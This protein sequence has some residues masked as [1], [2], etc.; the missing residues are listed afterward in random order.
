MKDWRKYPRDGASR[1]ENTLSQPLKEHRVF[2]N[3]KVLSEGWYPITLSKGLKKGEAASFKLLDQRL[4][5][6]RGMD[7]QVR[8]MDSF[9]PHMGADLGNGEVLGNK[10]RCYFHQWEFNGDG[11]VAKVPALET[12]PCLVKQGTYP[13]QEKYGQVWVFAGL[14]ADHE[15]PVAPG[16]E[17]FDA[18][19]IFIK[20]IKLFAHHHVLMAGGID[21]N[22]FATVHNLDMEFDF[23]VKEEGSEFKWELEGTLPLKGLKAK[24]GRILLGP[25]FRY[26]MKFSGGSVTSITYGH[27]QRFG[28][29]GI[30]LP[31]L[32]ILWGAIPQTDGVSKVK[33]FLLTKKRKGFIGKLK[34]SFLYLLTLFLLTI[35]RDEDAK[36]FPNMRFQLG[37]LVKGD[38]SVARLVGCLNKLPISPWYKTK[39]EEQEPVAEV[40][41]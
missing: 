21:L 2:N 15:V 41:N 28:G 13:V 16:L 10:L 35:L 18:D 32:H 40:W 30:E 20:E 17:D 26:Q 37:H 14:E 27:N 22:H 11:S 24:L 33:I 3:N 36:A 39:K 7:G 12:P 8:A 6:F 31:S 25:Q 23:S 19:A 1:L 38:E 34:N 9:C 29:S 4:A 5:L